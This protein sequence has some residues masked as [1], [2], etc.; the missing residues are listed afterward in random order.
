M[1]LTSWVSWP[2]TSSR[3]GRLLVVLQ[4]GVTLGG[5]PFLI[6]VLPQLLYMFQFFVDLE[7]MLSIGN[8]PAAIT[9]TTWPNYP[10]SGEG[11][12]TLHDFSPPTHTHTTFSRVSAWMMGVA[13]ILIQ[14]QARL[15]SM[16]VYSL[17]LIQIPSK[18]YPTRG[19]CSNVIPVW[20]YFL[21][22]VF[23]HLCWNVNFHR[24][25]TEL[26]FHV[27]SQFGPW[28]C[29]CIP[30]DIFLPLLNSISA[31]CLCRMYGYVVIVCFLIDVSL[32]LFAVT[33]LLLV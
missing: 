19:L 4:E 32:L 18:D 23:P 31:V 20:M 16:N 26:W 25:C 24:I 33:S 22:A 5:S 15:L 3:S 30:S 27:L 21:C 28:L 12:G 11:W 29:L 2:P 13:W 8:A 6:F 10:K 7:I 1:R 9:Q 14:I 17:V